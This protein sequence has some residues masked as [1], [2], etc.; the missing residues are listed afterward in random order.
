MTTTTVPAP[1]ASSHHQTQQA[2]VRA[3]LPR[4]QAHGLVCFRHVAY[5]A[6]ALARRRPRSAAA[7]CSTATAAP[8]WGRCG[9][10]RRGGW[11]GTAA[12]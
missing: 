1:Q 4:L 9:A 12:C 10:G 2:F 8:G 7:P 5:R 6:S 3:V 11:T